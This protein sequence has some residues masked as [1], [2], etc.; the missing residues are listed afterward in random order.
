VGIFPD[1]PENDR[2]ATQTVLSRPLEPAPEVAKGDARKATSRKLKRANQVRCQS[3]TPCGI[4]HHIQP[5]LRSV[6]V[7]R[8][9][10]NG[11]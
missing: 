2:V 8:S 3:L 9:P 4:N 5:I 10:A 6:F 1:A 11:N 7:Q